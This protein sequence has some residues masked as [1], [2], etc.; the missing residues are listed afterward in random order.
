MMKNKLYIIVAYMMKN[1]L[2][3]IIAYI[4]Y[5]ADITNTHNI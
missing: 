5:Y 2:Y 3:I 1:K 4:I